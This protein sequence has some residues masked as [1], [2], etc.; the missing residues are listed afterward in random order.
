MLMMGYGYDDSAIQNA[1]WMCLSKQI[2]RAK[3]LFQVQRFR[4]LANLN[5]TPSGPV[6]TKYSIVSLLVIRGL[7]RCSVSF[8][9]PGRLRNY[10]Y[11]HIKEG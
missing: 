3:E 9:K 2:H 11:I 4:V 1:I 8:T 10:I 7:P 5:P 6:T